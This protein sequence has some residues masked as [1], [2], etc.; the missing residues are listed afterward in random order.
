MV[1]LDGRPTGKSLREVLKEWAEFRLATV[2]RRSQYRLDQVLDR[3]HVLEGRMIVLLNVDA[4]IKVIREADDPKADIMA[5]FGLTERQADD[6]LDMRLRQLAKL[7]HFKV[8]KELEDKRK[9]QKELERILGS[10]RELLA[11]STALAVDRDRD[12]S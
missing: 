7:E 11:W 1:G 2:T 6:I 9:E 3:I 12:T 5:A 4:V 8:E 10:R